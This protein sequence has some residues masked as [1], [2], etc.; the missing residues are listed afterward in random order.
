M[1]AQTADPAMIDTMRSTSGG[2]ENKFLVEAGRHSYA[3]T[4]AKK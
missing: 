2:L 1:L 3:P 4:E